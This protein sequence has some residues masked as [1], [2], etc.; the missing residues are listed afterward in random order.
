MVGGSL[1]SWM[2]M[3]RVAVLFLGTISGNVCTSYIVK[4]T[5]CKP[6][7][8]LQGLNVTLRK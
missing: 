7:Q 5:I 3:Y 2:V 6:E 8:S 1:T 4:L